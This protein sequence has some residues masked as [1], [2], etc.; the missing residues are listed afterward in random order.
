[1]NRNPL[2]YPPQMRNGGLPPA[3]SPSSSLSDPSAWLQYK[4]SQS[5]PRAPN[6]VFD[7]YQ[8]FNPPADVG[9]PLGD[10]EW[11]QQAFREDKQAAGILPPDPP[12]GPILLEA[13]AFAED[14]YRA[15]K[16]RV[17]YLWEDERHRL[18][19]AARQRHL[20]KETARQRLLDEE[21][22]RCQRLLDEEAACCLMAERA[23]LVR[24][25]VAARTIFLW[26]CCRRLH[27]WLARQTSQ[28]QQRKAVL[29]HLQYP[30][31]QRAPRELPESSQ[32]S[33]Q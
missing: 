10:E 20:D 16:W 21:T 17:D 8:K 6:W 32:S 13:R 3:H 31:L 27:I 2:S 7:N 29:A 1:M 9:C 26:L 19:T 24:R 4:W 14:A 30:Q 5:P 33:L 18:Q 28:Q 12:G 11:H 25:M 23:A 15:W 22:A